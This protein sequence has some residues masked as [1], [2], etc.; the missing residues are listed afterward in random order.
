MYARNIYAITII[1]ILTIRRRY[2]INWETAHTGNSA[3]QEPTEGSREM[4]RFSINE[5]AAQV[6]QGTKSSKQGQPVDESQEPTERSRETSRFSNNEN[7]AHVNWKKQQINF[8]C[9]K[10][11]PT[12]L[13]KSPHSLY[14][15]FFLLLTLLKYTLMQGTVA[16][17]KKAVKIIHKIML[18]PKI[19][20]RAWHLL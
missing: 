6:D 5:I 19:M 9:S 16:A 20:F 15:F 4:G 2:V 17:L 18:P 10:G 3:L 1:N 8:E 14:N 7:T 13:H 11:T 12:S